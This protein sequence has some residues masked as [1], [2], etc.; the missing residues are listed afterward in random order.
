M[1]LVFAGTPAVAVPSLDALEQAGHEIA[2]VLTRPDAPLGRRKV[3]T[4]SPVA[5]RAEALHIPLIKAD[6]VDASVTGQLADC[7]PDLAVV[8]AYG[9]LVPP[10][11]L[12]VPRY[13]WLN[14]HFSLLPSWRGA[15]PVQHAVIHG[16]D[17]TG[18]STFKLEA[19]MDTGPVYGQLTEQ[20]HPTDTSGVLLE[21]LADSGAVLLQR[22]VDG[23]EA[24]SVS[25]STQSGQV[26]MAP[27]LT[28]EDGR[29]DWTH[30]AVAI[31]RRIR[32]VTPEP[33]AWTT[34]DN[35]RFKLGPVTVENSGL[36]LDPG[37]VVACDGGKAAIAGTG[38]GN[39]RLHRVQPAGR[40]F[41]DAADWL[42]GAGGGAGNGAGESVVFQ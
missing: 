36:A 34:L 21:R 23:L 31:D 12:D 25:A 37:Q 41:M 10:A 29:I 5:Q 40:K 42:R 7:A 33:G 28:V 39:I 16:D 17:V 1:K 14:L 38:S 8:V 22:T 15:A 3:L 18:A 35:E 11:A 32:G 20:I 19:G 27:K 30:P 4:P 13:G 24:G 26:S 9:A 6:R 2:A